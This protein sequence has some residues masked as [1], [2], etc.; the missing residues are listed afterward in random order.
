M[1]LTSTFPGSGGDSSFIQ[2]EIRQ[3]A[4]AFDRV[5][6]FSFMSPSAPL[7]E[8]PNN[9]DYVGALQTLPRLGS[10]TALVNPAMLRRVLLA[11]ARERSWKR[12][13]RK[14][15]LILGNAL[16]GARFAQGI[17]KALA[18]RGV[19][20]DDQV[21]IY[22][23]WGSHSA[24]ALPFLPARCEKFFRLHGF[25]LYEERGNPPPLRA[26]LFATADKVL[27]ISEHGAN[28]LSE[29]YPGLLDSEKVEVVRLGTADHGFTQ[30]RRRGEADGPIEIV[31]CSSVSSGKRVADILP[32]VLELSQDRP[33]RWTHCGDGPLLAD[34]RREVDAALSEH[35]NL[36]V[37]L[38]GYLPN[39]ELMALYRSTPFDV[40]VSVSDAEGVPVSIMEALSFDVPVVATNAGGTG[41]LVGEEKGTG[42]LLPLR[43]SVQ[44]LVT[45][46]ETVLDSRA[47][48]SPRE[49][50]EKKSDA[51]LTGQQ[52]ADLL[53][54]EKQTL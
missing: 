13:E 1:M 8:L 18:S 31:S 36:Q 32:A 4:D 12:S 7:R 19:A 5:F 3:L 47:S 24:M 9:V 33:V 16:T 14:P 42:I 21:A 17:Q 22:S 38:P 30:A 23:F 34:L 46:I 45:A 51:R 41:E 6:V 29:S 53:S 35:P 37:E 11:L 40:F 44:S 48:F 43:P 25:D 15:A 52:I 10:L 49:L 39:A 26:S 50:W 2:H 27:P 28:Y 54:G 20:L